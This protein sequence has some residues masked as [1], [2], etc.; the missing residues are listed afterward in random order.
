VGSCECGDEPW[1]SGATE[2]VSYTP[3]TLQSICTYYVKDTIRKAI[4]MSELQVSVIN[5]FIK[6]KSHFSVTYSII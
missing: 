1:G 6:F 5:S 3:F 2:L 4:V